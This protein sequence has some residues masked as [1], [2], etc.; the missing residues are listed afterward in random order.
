MGRAYEKAALRLEDVQARLG[1]T[2]TLDQIEDRHRDE[3]E[4]VHGAY[5]VEELPPQLSARQERK[6]AAWPDRPAPE[7]EPDIKV[8]F[9]GRF[10]RMVDAAAGFIEDTLHVAANLGGHLARAVD[11]ALGAVIGYFVDEPKLTAA[12]VHD[13]LQARGN[14]ETIHANE[15]AL[16]ASRTWRRM[17]GKAP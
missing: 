3:Y 12:Q 17:S 6:Y 10:G 8:G 16:A 11:I 13:T 2:E 7:I 4:R 14:V 5:G 9:L 1:V 15:V